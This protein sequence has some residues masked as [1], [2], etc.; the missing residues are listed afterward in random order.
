MS[1]DLSQYD[2]IIAIDKSGS[3]SNPGTH[4]ATRWLEAQE[5]TLAIARKAETFDQD[6]ITVIPFANTHKIYDGVTADKVAQ[7]FTENEPNGGTD[8]AGVLKTIFDRYAANPVKPI[9][10]VV[11]TDGEPNDRNAV[12]SVIKNFAET[13]TDNG[14]GDTDQAGILFLQVGNDS[15]AT[16][17]LV[18]LDDNLGAKFD[19][20]DTKTIDDAEGL[21]LADLLL[22]ALEG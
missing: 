8:T 11:V 15:A 13:L 4:A 3:M 7:I 17:F 10:V 19:I 2:V 9:I 6:G 14:S 12:K 18:E 21:T 22:Q 16:D 1:K 20:V 5:A